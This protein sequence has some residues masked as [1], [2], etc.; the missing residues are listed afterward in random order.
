MNY[1]K[2]DGGGQLPD[3]D[4]VLMQQIIDK[5]GS[6]DKFRESF[7]G[8]LLS[9]QGS[10][11]GNLALCK[12]TGKVIYMETKDQDPVYLQANKVPL[13]CIDAWEH[14]WYPKYFNEKKKYFENIW[15]IINWKDVERRFNSARQ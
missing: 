8:N 7:T 3:K 4:S 11:W 9:I 2:I 12:N 14:A 5:W 13:M 1:L 15:K 10:G 6:F